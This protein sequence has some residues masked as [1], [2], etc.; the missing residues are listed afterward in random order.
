MILSNTLH[1]TL[2]RVGFDYVRY[3]PAVHP[4][5]RHRKLLESFAIDLVLDVGANRGQTGKSFRDLGF[6]GRIISFEPLQDAFQILSKTAQRD[7]AWQAYN[8]ALGSSDM[9]AAINVSGNSVASSLLDMLPGHVN[10]TPDSHYIGQQ[11]I[12]VRTLDS[13]FDSLSEKAHNIYLKIDTQ[14]FEKE[15]L[16]GAAKSLPRIATLQLELSFVPL[17]RDAPLFQDVC[18]Y[19]GARDYQLVSLEPVFVD[20]NTGRILQMDGIFHRYAVGQNQ[21]G[22]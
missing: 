9:T 7:D 10:L 11:Q 6:K 20:N 15:V 18:E 1:R 21:Y 12:E 17:Y 4:R 8:F 13:L 14:G 2:R 5:A 19:L 22:N 16:A 3:I